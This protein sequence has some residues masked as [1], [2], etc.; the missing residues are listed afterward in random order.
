LSGHL[1]ARFLDTGT[2]ARTF[3]WLRPYSWYLCNQCLV[4]L[5]AYHFIHINDVF[6]M[7]PESNCNFMLS[8]W[9]YSYFL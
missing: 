1:R 2:E 5:P 4:I 7:N 3:E 6:Q 8:V 9:L